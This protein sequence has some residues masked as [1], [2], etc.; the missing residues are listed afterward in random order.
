MAQDSLLLLLLI[1]SLLHPHHM[2]DP[3]FSIMQQK[4]T[5][6][7]SHTRQKPRTGIRIKGRKEKI[8]NMR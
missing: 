2:P 8:E 3:V 4:G 6:S 5:G 1:L 7:L